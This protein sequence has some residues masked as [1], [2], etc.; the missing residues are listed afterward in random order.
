KPKTGPIKQSAGISRFPMAV[1]CFSVAR[2]P[3]PAQN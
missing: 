1:G 3:A 2:P